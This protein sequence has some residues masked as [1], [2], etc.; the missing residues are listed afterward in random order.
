MNS[1]SL[2]HSSKSF[3]R[4]I[5]VFVAM[6]IQAIPFAIAQNIQPLF[7]PHI[8]DEFGFTLSGF[9]LIFTIG[10]LASSVAS[11]LLGKLFGKIPIKFIFLM[12]TA[13]SSLGFFMFS[14]CDI[15]PEFYFWNAVTQVGCIFFSA[16]GIPYLIEQWFPKTGRGR[17][18]GIAFAGGAIGNIFLQQIAEFLISSY[19]TSKTYAIFGIVSAAFSLPI[20]ALFI[21]GPK[22]E[23]LELNENKEDLKDKPIHHHEF[24]GL[25]V[26]EN[27]KNPSFWIFGLGYSILGISISALSTQYATYFANGLKFT[28]EIVGIL[29]SLFAIFGLIGNIAG[30]TLFDKLGTLKTMKI[31]MA[32][33]IIALGALLLASRLRGVA[34]VYSIAYGLNVFS[35]ISAPAIMTT[36]LFG[37]KDSSVMLGFVQLF[38][39]V[40]FA[41]GS[42][43]FGLIVDKTGGFNVAWTIMLICAVI[44]YILLLGAIKSLKKKKL[45]LVR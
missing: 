25:G 19:G 6:L 32:L 29:G 7:I 44:G 43:I 33:Q 24:E 35:F 8:I 16:L 9:S 15:L 26:S 12:G 41:F 31:A 13:I 22:E 36:D 37:K 10:A 3:K 40:G 11:P 27:T 28:P 23:E 14:T 5:I 39:A 20:I 18:L 4:S 45:E 21:R 30:G 42:T 1:I 34:F 2:K 17:A 38:F